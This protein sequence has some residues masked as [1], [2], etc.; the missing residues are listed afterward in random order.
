MQF[1]LKI[2]TNARLTLEEWLLASVSTIP[3]SAGWGAIGCRMRRACNLVPTVSTRDLARAACRL[4]LLRTFNPLLSRAAVARVRAG[5]LEW[6]QLCVLED[7]LGRMERFARGGMK[8]DL[9]NELREL[10]RPKWVN[11]IPSTLNSQ[12]STL[13]PKP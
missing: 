3:S 11:P 7:K 1:P 2:I 4:G 5:V 6:L 8:Q 10:E 13:N 12:L 9:E